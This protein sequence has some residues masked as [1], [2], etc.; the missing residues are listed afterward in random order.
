MKRMDFVDGVRPKIID[1]G[2]H[3]PNFSLREHVDQTMRGK[4]RLSSGRRHLSAARGEERRVA[5][6]AHAAMFGR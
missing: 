1:I 6:V 3:L 4:V 2:E 5:A